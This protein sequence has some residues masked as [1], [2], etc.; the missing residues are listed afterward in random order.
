[1]PKTTKKTAKSK[2]P[3]KAQVKAEI[4]KSQLLYQGA[5]SGDRRGATVYM[6]ADKLSDGKTHIHADRLKTLPPDSWI[7]T[8]SYAPRNGSNANNT[9]HCGPYTAGAIGP[10]IEIYASLGRQLGVYVEVEK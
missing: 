2:K 8:I 5:D 10:A 1:M 7:L 9:R 3:T 6:F 4:E